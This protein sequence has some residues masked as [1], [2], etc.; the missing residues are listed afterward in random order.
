MLE[1]ILL[2]QLLAVMG[3]QACGVYSAV[4]VTNGPSVWCTAN[5][6]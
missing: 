1:R 6:E 2:P 4:Q 3:I 5:L